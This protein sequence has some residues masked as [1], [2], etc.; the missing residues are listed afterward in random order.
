LPWGLLMSIPA[1]MLQ[2]SDMF[3][4]QLR[5]AVRG[6]AILV[7]L[8]I[9]VSASGF[10]VLLLTLLKRR[11]PD[12]ST[13]WFAVFCCL[14]GIRLLART[15]SIRL[16]FD[17]PPALCRSRTSATFGVATKRTRYPEM[18]GKRIN[19]WF[20]TGSQLHERR[21]SDIIE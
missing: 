14:Y 18:H 16:L 6:D 4:E 8:G 12:H 2:A 5:A 7:V 19:P 9:I 11:S 20:P 17:T 13:L 1:V 21:D 10:A 3:Q 15:Q